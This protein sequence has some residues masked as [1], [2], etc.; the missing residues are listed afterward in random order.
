M[1]EDHAKRET[2]SIDVN[3]LFEV[4][5]SRKF[6][7]LQLYYSAYHLVVLSFSIKEVVGLKVPLKTVFY[8]TFFSIIPFSNI[9]FCICDVLSDFVPFVQI[10]KRKKHP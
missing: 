6:L 2:D 4:T 1:S 8:I 10:K 9:L 3:I 7:F 5:S